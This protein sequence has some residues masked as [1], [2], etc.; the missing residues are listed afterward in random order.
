[1]TLHIIPDW[2]AYQRRLPEFNDTVHQVQLFL[3]QGQAVALVVVDYLPNLRQILFHGQIESAQIWSAYDV[4]QRVQLK[5]DLS[6][7]HI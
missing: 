6:L 4:L 2:H 3:S 1:M 7:I 5:Y